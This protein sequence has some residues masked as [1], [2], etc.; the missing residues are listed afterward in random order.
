MGASLDFIKKSI[1]TDD[2]FYI[3]F[4]PKGEKFDIVKMAAD[5]W[6][7]DQ[8]FCNELFNG[9]NP[10]TIRVVEPSQVRDAFRLLSDESGSSIDLDQFAGGNLF[11]SQYPE[12]K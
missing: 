9:C 6:Y 2:P 8:Y 1:A 11:I 10:Y 3:P 5:N 12:L 7:T 4:I